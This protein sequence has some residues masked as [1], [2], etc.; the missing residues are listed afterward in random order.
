[1]SA[2]IHPT[3]IVS[4]E[5][6]IAQDVEIGPWCVIEGPVKLG[7]GVKIFSHA[8]LAGRTQ[9]GAQCRIYPFASL[10]HAPQIFP[11]MEG[12]GALVVGPRTIIREY[13]TMNPAAQETGRTHVGE[14]C[15]FMASSHV[16]HDCFVGDHAVFANHA[17][18]AGHCRIEDYAILSGGVMCQQHVRVGAHAFVGGMGGVT[19]DVPPFLY[20]W[21]IPARLAG[22]NAVGL[23]RRGFSRERIHALRA[24]YQDLFENGSPAGRAA[25]VERRF[26]G[27]EDVRQLAGFIRQSERPVAPARR[28]AGGG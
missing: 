12:K 2:R 26:A 27:N 16:A 20:A 23:K 14:G 25:Q 13:V 7:P 21:G 6:E 22:V 19:H 5:A 8:A 24:A 28:R 4:P 9:I 1:M 11:P 15:M 17:T 18:L 10:G 3:S